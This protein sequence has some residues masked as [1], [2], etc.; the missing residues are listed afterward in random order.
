MAMLRIYTVSCRMALCMGVFL[1]TVSLSAFASEPEVTEEVVTSVP[2][3]ADG[4]VWLSEGLNDALLSIAAGPQGAV[5]AL[6]REGAVFRQSGADTW[7]EV[8]SSPG[9]RLDD[10]SGVDEE[11]LLLDAEGFLG[12]Q[13]DQSALTADEVRSRQTVDA[14]DDDPEAEGRR[15]ISEPNVDDSDLTDLFIEQDG[16]ADSDAGPKAGRLVWLSTDMVGLAMVSRGDG[17]WRSLD[18]GR[19]WVP[20]GSVAPIYSLHDVPGRPGSVIAGTTQGLR[21]SLDS[22][23]T[24]KRVKDPIADVVVYGFDGDG[25]TLYAGTGEGLFRSTDGVRWAKV[26]SRY[27]SDVP[28]WH[29]AVDRYWEGG[30]WVVGPVG[31]LRSDDGG[32]NLRQ[33]SRNPM[34]GT[35][36][37]LPLE[38]AGHVLASGIDGVWES[39]DGG[40]RWRPIAAGLPSPSNEVLVH[41]LD[42]P[43]LAGVD[44]VFTLQRAVMSSAAPAVESVDE[45][46]VNMS[47]L[48]RVS[49]VRPGMA[50]Q[51]ILTQRA[52]MRSLLLPKFNIDGRMTQQRMLSADHE[53]RTNRGSERIGW[54]IGMTM[55]FG[56]CSSVSGFSSLDVDA[57]VE[58]AES[59]ATEYSELAVV[60]NEVYVADTSGSLT[61]MAANVAERMTRYRSEVANRV[62]ELVL[63]RHRLIEARGVVR[64][65][66]LREQVG[67]ELDI[68]E[69]TARIDVYTNGY[70]TRIQSGS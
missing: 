15:V 22:G 23:A 46:V 38:R 27:D 70:F 63:S 29:V 43:I 6:A 51:E 20:A 24:W 64:T 60:G 35:S 52:V 48:V 34:R 49:L 40:M 8:L 41:G 59:G 42:R 56:P 33:L 10:G 7:L 1:S 50:M 45:Q 18:S 21:I 54:T 47:E 25:S 2:P 13:E 62:S 32:E 44:G 12:E 17:L 36:R 26:L 37:L 5:L 66:S 68:L 55:C 67:H 39:T 19:T 9:L 65:L 11:G 4:H 58:L 3:Y 16:E 69:S 53:A 57:A 14:A 31:I 61:P 28:V 30:L